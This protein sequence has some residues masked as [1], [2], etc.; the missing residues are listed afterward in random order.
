MSNQLHG[1]TIEDMIKSPFRGASDHYR[2]TTSIFDI[3]A[4]F[5]KDF[6]LNTSIK[7]SKKKYY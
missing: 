1:K 7:A 6:N 3:E 2:K 5:D 4:D